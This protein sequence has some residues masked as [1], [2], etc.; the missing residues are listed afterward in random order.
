MA[1]DRVLRAEF[2]YRPRATAALDALYLARPQQR[3]RIRGLLGTAIVG[4]VI[5]VL[6]AVSGAVVWLWAVCLVVAALALAVVGW[7]ALTLCQ[8]S[9][10]GTGPGTVHVDD[11]GLLVRPAGGEPVL[12]AWSSLRGWAQTDTVVVLFPDTPSG[13]PL[14]VIPAPDVRISASAGVVRE[15]LHWHLGRPRE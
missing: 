10:F 13:R 6:A 8:G 11:H 7:W 4:M 15:L 12:V 9:V 2:S 14:H 1:A 3:A 5:G